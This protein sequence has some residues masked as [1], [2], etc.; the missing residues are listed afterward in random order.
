MKFKHAIAA[1]AA[2]LLLAACGD[3]VD[4]TLVS[5]EV[6]ASAM[7]SSRAYAAYVGSLAKDDTATPL[8]VNNVKAPTTETE[9]PTVL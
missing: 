8:E 6:P 7:E 5:N 9:E 4:D 1:S 2:A 3:S